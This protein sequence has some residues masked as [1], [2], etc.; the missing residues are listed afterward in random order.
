MRP[1]LRCRQ[2]SR[3]TQSPDKVQVA[4][5][6]SIRGCKCFLAITEDDLTNNVRGGENSGRTLTHSAVVREPAS[7]GLH[8]LKGSSIRR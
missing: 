1:R 8:R 4:V 7:A 6:N 3:Y 5:N 2:R